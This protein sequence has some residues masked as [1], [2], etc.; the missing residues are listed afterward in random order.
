MPVIF[1]VTFRLAGKGHPKN[2]KRARCLAQIALRC[3]QT[4]LCQTARTLTLAKRQEDK[5]K[6]DKALKKALRG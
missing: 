1:L 3:S 2:C 4:L 5:N 6:A